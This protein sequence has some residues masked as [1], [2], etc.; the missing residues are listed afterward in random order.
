MP[1]TLFRSRFTSA[2]NICTVYTKAQCYSLN[3]SS[4]LIS[5]EWSLNVVAADQCPLILTWASKI[6]MKQVS[7]SLERMYLY[8][9]ICKRWEHHFNEYNS[10]KVMITWPSMGS[11]HVD[12]QLLSVVK[13]NRTVCNG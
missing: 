2:I 12:F 5:L 4:V 9:V 11:M 13:E 3:R 7:I 6:L 1:S 8:S 10:K